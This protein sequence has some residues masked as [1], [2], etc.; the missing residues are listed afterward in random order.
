MSPGEGALEL[1]MS[2]AKSRGERLFTLDFALIWLAML[3]F[4]T[5]YNAL[6]PTLPP[7]V[8]RIGGTEADVG[9]V[10]GV[11][12]LA[13]VLM[14][15]VSGQWI[16][17]GHKKTLLAGG[18]IVF[19]VASILYMAIPFLKGLVAVRLLHGLG[20][21]MYSTAASS[22]T[23]DAAPPARRG[24]ALGYLMLATSMS[25]AIG[26]AAGLYVVNAFSYTALFWMSAALALT[27][28]AC[29]TM[30]RTPAQQ[31]QQ[32]R[33]EPGATSL[34]AFIGTEALFPAVVLFL[35]SATYGSIAS[36]VA[37][38]AESRGVHN[39]GAFFTAFA[40]SMFVT[41]V[42][43]GRLSDRFGRA[44]VIIPSFAMICIG[45]ALLATAKS[46]AALVA[47]AAF[48]GMGYSTMQPM[49]TAYTV[50]NVSAG[51]RG[52]AIGT[53][54]AMYDMGIAMG[55]I[56][57]GRIASAAPLAAIYWTMAAV[58]GLGMLVFAAGQARFT[59]RSAVAHDTVTHGS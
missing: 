31:A 59:A 24:E 6:I 30:V 45:M 26:P 46:T 25:M 19:F 41:R 29:V 56:V 9:V 36:F 28:L 38:Y 18:A 55:G 12:P 42:F 4:Y 3:L 34:S 27:V 53:L 39:S 14:R 44:H 54:L 13:S 23:A 35:G 52:V 16:D 57:S 21:G 48:Y 22:L 51:R 32:A 2:T 40:V 37:L 7:Y 17:R 49:I 20:L 33:Q 58:G 43:S 11:L 10:M 47:A 15:L 5:S 8:L 1:E 50:D